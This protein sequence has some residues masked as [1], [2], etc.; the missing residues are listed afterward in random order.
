MRRAFILVNTD[1]GSELAVQAE[2]K[3]VHGIVGVYQVYGVYDILVEIEAESDQHLK[4]II[5]S[6]IR[7]LDHV[8]STITLTTVP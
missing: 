5:F 2:L 1:L 4:D 7:S 3:K 8:R 6:G